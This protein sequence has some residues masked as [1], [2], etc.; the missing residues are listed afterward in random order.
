M[1]NGGKQCFILLVAYKS[2]VILC[3]GLG[4]C[5]FIGPHII[6]KPL[7]V[8]SKAGSFIEPLLLTRSLHGA[9]FSGEPWRRIGEGDRRKE[10]VKAEG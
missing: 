8:D 1:I 4:E 3:L 6:F 5:F 10:K 9:E 2:G 7:K